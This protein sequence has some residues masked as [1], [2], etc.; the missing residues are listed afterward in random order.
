MAKLRMLASLVPLQFNI[1]NIA[2]T[3]DKII[4]QV[5]VKGYLILEKYS[6]SPSETYPELDFTV[7]C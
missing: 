5:T 1:H 3:E 2:F 6:L 4:L 7:K